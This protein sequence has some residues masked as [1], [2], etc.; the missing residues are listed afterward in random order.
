MSFL[1]TLA[2]ALKGGADQRVPLARGYLSPWAG[3]YATPYAAPY[4]PG[5]APYDYARSVTR[6]YCDNPVAQR[7]VRLVTEG[8]AS[9]PL[10]ASD[11]ALLALVTA[12]S[13][14]QSLLEAWSPAGCQLGDEF[15]DTGRRAQDQ[16]R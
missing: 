9:A 12:T 15:G 1:A 5:P 3:A 6:A 16:D 13:A 11:P 7:A 14:G 10:S 4:A 8:V 2:A